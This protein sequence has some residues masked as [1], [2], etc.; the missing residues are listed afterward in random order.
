MKLHYLITSSVLLLISACTKET[1]AETDTISLFD[2]KTLEG[3]RTADPDKAHYWSVKDGIIE[4]SNGE[5]KM[6][7]NTYLATTTEYGDFEFTC[8]FRLSGDF[9]TGLINSGIQYRSAINGK[10]MKGYQADIGKGYWGDV[11]DEGTRRGKLV[12]ANTEELFKDFKHDD[13]HTYK[14]ICKGNHHQLFINGFL[15]ADYKEL[16]ENYPNKGLIALQLHSGGIAK[17]QYKN[18]ILKKL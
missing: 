16:D 9:K 14:I 8:E 3:W 10:H 5:K 12:K 4:A 17:I 7:K 6:P 13:W 15:T 2:G 18:I 11:Y 1:P